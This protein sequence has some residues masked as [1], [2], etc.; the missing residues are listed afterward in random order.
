MHPEPVA[1]CFQRLSGILMGACLAKITFS[2]VNQKI[3][4]QGQPV[5]NQHQFHRMTTYVFGRSITALQQHYFL[6]ICRT[7]KVK[8]INNHKWAYKCFFIFAFSVYCGWFRGKQ[9]SFATPVRPWAFQ[10]S[11]TG[12]CTSTLALGAFRFHFRFKLGS[13][14]L[15]S[16]ICTNWLLSFLSLPSNHVFT[17]LLFWRK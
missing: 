2:P 8:L 12:Q 7:D 17:S 6:C 16:Q 3:E 4:T 15:S 9:L 1:P 11:R 10:L 14:S 13:N 5:Q